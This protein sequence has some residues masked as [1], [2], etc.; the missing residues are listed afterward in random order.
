MGIVPLWCPA[1]ARAA[2][3]HS[4]GGPMF[5]LCAGLESHCNC[6]YFQPTVE[7]S[8]LFLALFCSR[9]FSLLFSEVVARDTLACAMCCMSHVFR[10]CSTQAN[11]TR[12]RI[13]DCLWLICSFLDAVSWQAKG[14][15]LDCGSF[16][17]PALLSAASLLTSWP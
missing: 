8:F 14:R 5:C 10:A 1:Q 13:Q 11:A 15:T 2:E 4:C 16:G 7:P 9:W 12:A 17:N 6:S 3:S